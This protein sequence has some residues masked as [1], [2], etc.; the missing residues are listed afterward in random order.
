MILGILLGIFLYG[1]PLLVRADDVG[2]QIPLTMTFFFFPFQGILR[3]I[4]RLACLS[5]Q[6]GIL[7]SGEAAC[8]FILIL[9]I[10]F[11]IFFGISVLSSF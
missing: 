2:F 1:R 8:F 10:Y 7:C 5:A 3:L 6:P 11:S 9:P 4:L